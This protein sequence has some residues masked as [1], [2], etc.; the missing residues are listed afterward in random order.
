MESWTL[1]YSSSPPDTCDQL[2]DETLIKLLI[3][4]L[5]SSSVHLCLTSAVFFSWQIMTAMLRK[6]RSEWRGFCSSIFS[7]MIFVCVCVCRKTPGRTSTSCSPGSKHYTP[8]RDARGY[9][10]PSRFRPPWSQLPPASPR[11][12]VGWGLRDIGLGTEQ[13]VMW[14]LLLLRN[15]F[16]SPQ[17][18]SSGKCVGTWSD[19]LLV[20]SSQ[21]FSTVTCDPPRIGLVISSFLE[22]QMPFAN[23]LNILCVSSATG[24]CWH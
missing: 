15:T 3:R 12:H 16:H 24:L 7:E 2:E 23:I 4:P 22:C 19:V 8:E 21:I 11:V 6:W 14:F 9:E 13:V 20:Y 18:T 10:W 1:H 5:I 17:A